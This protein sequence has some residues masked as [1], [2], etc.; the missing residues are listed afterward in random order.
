MFVYEFKYD[1]NTKDWV[2]APNKKKAISFYL[3][4]IGEHELSS[5]V[6]RIPKKDLSTMYILDLDIPEPYDSEEPYDEDEYSYGYKI[7]QTLADYV[8]NNSRTD[9]IATTEY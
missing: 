7:S 2:F 5:E 3:N 1:R 8:K 9:I 4:H 6:R